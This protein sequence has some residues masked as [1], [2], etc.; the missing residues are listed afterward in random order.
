MLALP[1]KIMTENNIPQSEV[2]GF[3]NSTLMDEW[4][5]NNQNI[6]AGGRVLLGGG[7]ESDLHVWVLIC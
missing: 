3:A 7:E 2:R 5:Y 6:T 4:I 1:Q